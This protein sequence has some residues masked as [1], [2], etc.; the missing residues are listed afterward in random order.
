MKRHIVDFVFDNKPD[1]TIIIENASSDADAITKATKKL[2]QEL[3]DLI[4]RTYVFEDN[5]ED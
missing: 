3:K 4:L 1:E 2:T 5:D